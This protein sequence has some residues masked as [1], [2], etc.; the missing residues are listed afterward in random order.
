M[1][2]VTLDPRVRHTGPAFDRT[3]SLSQTRELSHI[4]QGLSGWLRPS[5]IEQIFVDHLGYARVDTGAT[6][7]SKTIG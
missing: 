3:N 7:S 5:F 6:I 4:L 2:T 1:L